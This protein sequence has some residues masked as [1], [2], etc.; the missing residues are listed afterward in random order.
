MLNARRVLPE[1]LL[2]TRCLLYASS[3]ACIVYC[4]HYLSIACVVY[5]MHCLL[6]ALSVACFQI[7]EEDLH[8]AAGKE[9]SNRHLQDS[10][11]QHAK[12]L[13]GR[14]L[15]AARRY[16]RRVGDGAPVF[17]EHNVRRIIMD[18]AFRWLKCPPCRPGGQES[19]IVLKPWASP[20]N[21][22]LCPINVLLYGHACTSEL[23]K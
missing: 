12:Q 3:V 7:R 17:A 15:P 11:W 16:L 10:H 18:M 1:S 19:I 21:S 23:W 5:C 8:T 14:G 20:S 13:G 4:L 9:R 6:H 22:L 2:V